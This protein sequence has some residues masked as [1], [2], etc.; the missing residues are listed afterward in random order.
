MRTHQLQPTDAALELLKHAHLTI[1]F[2]RSICL[3][4]QYLSV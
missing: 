3:D 1:G 2:D 4:V